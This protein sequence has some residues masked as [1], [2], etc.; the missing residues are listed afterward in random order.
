MRPN[1]VF[2]MADDMGYGDPGCY[3]ATTIRTPHCDRLAREGRRFTDAH[4]PAASCSP[5]R[6]GL[7]TGSYPW[8]EGRVP[9][10]LSASEAYKLRDGEPTVA[11]LLKNAGYATACVG[12]WH[13][14]TQ[15]KTPVDWNA[16]L[17]PGPRSQ[18]PWMAD[19]AITPV[20]PLAESF[21]KI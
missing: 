2:I 7:L 12:K 16:P 13:L 10:A 1:I 3:G 11:S 17:T 6:F 14:G 20:C 5:T 4:T 15:R 21:L 9:G 19:P 18:P 8:R